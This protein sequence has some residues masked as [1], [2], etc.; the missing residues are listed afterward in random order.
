MMHAETQ[1]RWLLRGRVKLP[2]G[3]IVRDGKR[4]ALSLIR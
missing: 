1:I 4:S 3:G 2:T